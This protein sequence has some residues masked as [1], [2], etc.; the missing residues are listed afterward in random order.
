MTLDDKTRFVRD[1]QRNSE[2]ECTGTMGRKAKN[3]DEMR[4]HYDFSGGVRGKYAAR[5]ARLPII[6]I[7]ANGV[8]I[9]RVTLTGFDEGMG[10]AT[11]PF[12]PSARYAEVRPQ[13]TAAAEARHQNLPSKNVE[14]E[15]RTTTGEVISTGFVQIDDF[16]DVDVD[17]EASIQFSD[18][19][20]L[21]RLLETAVELRR[22]GAA[23]AKA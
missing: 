7:F 11:G 1:S 14:L 20:R 22:S 17:P 23:K 9:G 4:D 2:G 6:E 13:I 12:R 19:D 15:A 21:L 8:L 5:Y 10:V 18:R 16:A 3:Q